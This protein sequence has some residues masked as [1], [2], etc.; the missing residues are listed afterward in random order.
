MVSFKRF[1]E[2]NL[3]DKSK[4]FSSLKDE[5]ISEKDYQRANNVWNAFKMN[6]MGDYHDFI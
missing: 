5:C 4:F 2:N 1:S 3:P 6:L